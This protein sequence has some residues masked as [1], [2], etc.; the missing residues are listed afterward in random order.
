MQYLRFVKKKLILTC[1]SKWLVH[2]TKFKNRMIKMHQNSIRK[3]SSQLA[4]YA[5]IK[6]YP[7]FSINAIDIWCFKNFISFST[8]IDICHHFYDLSKIHEAIS[9]FGWTVYGAQYSY[10]CAV[11]HFHRK[12]TNYQCDSNLITHWLCYPYVIERPHNDKNIDTH[13]QSKYGQ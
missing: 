13:W 4:K 5:Y 12:Y 2:W 8:F 7:I 6:H 11:G 1:K 9:Y 10:Q 3:S